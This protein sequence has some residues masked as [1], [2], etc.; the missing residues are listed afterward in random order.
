MAGP[1]VARSL[2]NTARVQCVVPPAGF[3]G[4][5][6]CVFPHCG[7]SA[8]LYAPKQCCFRLEHNRPWPV[9]ERSSTITFRIL[10]V[11]AFRIPC[12][13]DFPHTCALVFNLGHN[14]HIYLHMDVRLRTPHA[15]GVGGRMTVRFAPV[16][17]RFSCHRVA[18]LAPCLK[19]SE[20]PRNS[21]GNPHGGPA[22]IVA[23]AKPP[24]M[25]AT[26]STNAIRHGMA[27]GA[28]ACRGLYALLLAVW[29]RSAVQ[30]AHPFRVRCATGAAAPPLRSGP[31]GGS[32]WRHRF[33]LSVGL[34]CARDGCVCRAT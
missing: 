2:P 28:R 26:S 5:T 20:N 25:I 29:P 3:G 13:Y 24:S 14:T 30:C 33:S 12:V 32:G 6:P 22:T 19:L 8:K 17:E 10:A 16:T 23:K 11:H 15:S 4:F 21:Q 1:S 27:L 9:I 34:G 18:R 7:D 31:R